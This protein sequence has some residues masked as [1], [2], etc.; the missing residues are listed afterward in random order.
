MRLT[1]LLFASSL[2]ALSA[3]KKDAE[4]AATA[5]AEPD[6]TWTYFAMYPVNEVEVPTTVRQIKANAEDWYGRSVEG[7]VY[8]TSTPTD[9]GFWIQDP[10][11]DQMFALIQDAPRDAYKDIDPGQTLY[12]LDA[13]VYG[14]DHVD[15]FDTAREPLTKASMKILQ[16]QKA[17]LVVDESDLIILKGSSK[18]VSSAR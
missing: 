6:Y 12:L 2:L 9:R 7:R 15:K 14:P 11:G 13:R 3:C 17:Y 1:T 10:A 8:V 18:S 4:P 5:D 16:E